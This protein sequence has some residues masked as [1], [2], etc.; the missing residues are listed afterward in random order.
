MGLLSLLSRLARA[1]PAALASQ[2]LADRVAGVA[3]TVLGR[4]TGPTCGDLKVL[5][6]CDSDTAAMHVTL[7]H[8]IKAASAAGPC[9]DGGQGQGRSCRETAVRR[10]CAERRW[11]GAPVQRDGGQARLECL[12]RA[13]LEAFQARLECLYRARL[14]CLCMHGWMAR[15]GIPGQAGAISACLARLGI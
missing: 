7:R 4:L 6:A 9:I 15:T 5:P 8:V 13:R 1:V 2:E 10:A 12:C 14:E 11:S 3:A